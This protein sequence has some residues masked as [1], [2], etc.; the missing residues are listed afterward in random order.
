[1]LNASSEFDDSNSSTSSESEHYDPGETMNE[2]LEVAEQIMSQFCSNCG[3][4]NQEVMLDLV[5]SWEAYVVQLCRPPITEEVVEFTE[6]FA[7]TGVAEQIARCAVEN[8]SH[9]ELRIACMRAVYAFVLY[10]CEDQPIGCDW[11]QFISGIVP[12]WARLFV[13]LS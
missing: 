10:L 13:M 11:S 1:M 2:L 6:Q 8:F 4:C 7:K 3:H 5:L 9:A 12:Y